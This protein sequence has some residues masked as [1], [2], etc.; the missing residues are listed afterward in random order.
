MIKR[1]TLQ[2]NISFL[3]LYVPKKKISKDIQQKID[4]E[5]KRNRKFYN[6]IGNFNTDLSVIDKTIRQEDGKNTQDFNN[7]TNELDLMDIYN[8]IHQ[9]QNTNY[10]Q[11]YKENS[12]R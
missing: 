2:E 9:L 11:G 1:S 7:P 3:N 8:A 12:P 4:R 10:F 5:K 6:H